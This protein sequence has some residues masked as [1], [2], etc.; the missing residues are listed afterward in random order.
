MNGLTSDSD[1]LILV[2]EAD[3]SLGFLSKALCHEGRGVLHRAFS[4]LIFN[5]AGELLIQQRSAAKRLWPLYWSNS[6]CSHPRGEESME[7]A[8]RRRLYEELGIRCRLE[9]LFKFHYQAQFDATGAENELCSVF[10]GRCREPIRANSDEIA[11]W[12]WISPE[13]LQR[14]MAADA[15][16]TFT[17][18]FMLEW[19]R[20]W[21]DHRQAVL[22]I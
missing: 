2:D 8:A 12:G 1:A 11:D 7:S 13:R 14:E 22:V 20:I 21:R 5:E 6:C 9:F 15:G 10:V 3:R 16:R 19:A 4:L 17:P 18:W